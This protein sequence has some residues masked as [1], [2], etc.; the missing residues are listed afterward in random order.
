LTKQLGLANAFTSEHLTGVHT[1]A[2]IVSFFEQQRA[3]AGEG[4]GRESSEKKKSQ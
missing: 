4:E 1:L 3:N 2:E